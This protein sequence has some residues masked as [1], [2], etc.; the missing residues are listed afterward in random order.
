MEEVRIGFKVREFRT[1]RR[2]TVRALSEATGITSSMLSQIEREL[3]NP[4]I[5]TLKILAQ[6][7]GVPLWQFFRSGPSQDL[8]V[9]RDRRKTIGLPDN[10]DVRYELLTADTNGSI[11]F[12]EMIIPAEASSSIVP[13]SHSGE[14]TAFILE[15][16]ISV[17]LGGTD[18]ELNSSD[19]VRIPPMTEHYWKN[20]GPR[21]ARVLFA[22][23]PPSF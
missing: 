8:V 23:T 5:A 12:C 15:G 17:N 4:S 18:Y 21:V 9:R 6:A 20:H 16:P 14:E 22:I 19:S 1:M 3:V 10:R 7:L 13:Q 11:E 2:M